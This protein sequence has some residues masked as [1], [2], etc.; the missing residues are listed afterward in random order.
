MHQ[1]RAPVR[2]TPL[3]RPAE[4]LGRPFD[5]PGGPDA[6]LLLHGLSGSP[7]ELRALADRLYLEGMRCLGPVM[8]GHGGEPQALAGVLW[9]DWVARAREELLRL[10]GAR[11][12]FV[13]GCSM[14]ALVALALAHEHPERVD[15]LALLAPAL[16]LA[17]GPALGGFLARRTPLGAV[18][19]PLPKGTS[20]VRDDE[21][22]RL[23]PAM[24]SIPLS[25]V[26]ELQRL[27][28]HVDRILPGVAAPAIVFAGAKDHTVRL[29]GVKR[30]AR[31]I[32]SAPA[33]LVV[34]RDSFH[35]VG[36]DVERDV[37]AN[38][39]ATFFARVPVPGQAR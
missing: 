3:P 27:A 19:P 5:L 32:G 18:L 14:G 9:T 22:R 7:F 29:S 12:T 20:D 34:L 6:A 36:I 1:R 11:R 25:A 30:V 17:P 13:V 24:K 26:G 23:N 15:G 31:R 4:A 8:A 38:E 10:Q 21:M 16:R 2:R 39:V 35:L 33:R 28:D 37:V